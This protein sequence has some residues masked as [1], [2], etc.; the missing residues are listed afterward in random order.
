LSE[1]L[2]VL[3]LR[4]KVRVFIDWY[5]DFPYVKAVGVDVVERLFFSLI[6]SLSA[7]TFLLRSIST[8][9]MRVESSP[10]TQQLSLILSG[11]AMDEGVACKRRFKNIF[12]ITKSGK[13]P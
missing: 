2:Q 12:V 3:D 7:P 9:N 1:D 11:V 8:G 13:V 5:G 6:A 10:S 4:Y